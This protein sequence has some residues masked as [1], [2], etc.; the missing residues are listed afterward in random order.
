MGGSGPED[1]DR[2][3]LRIAVVMNGGVSLAVWISGVTIELH[4]VV[5]A[6]RAE[7]RE[8]WPE[9][10]AVLDLLQAQARID[11]VAGT[12]AGGLNGGFLALGLVRD[13]ELSGMRE[14]WRD[15]GDLGALLRDPL[16]RNPESLLQGDGYFLPRVREAYR[17]IWDTGRT[18]RSAEDA[19]VELMLTGTL[20]DGR[21]SS[22]TDDMGTRITE[23]DYDATFR[24]SNDL[25]TDGNSRGR[26]GTGDLTRETVIDELAVASR[27]TSS[28]PGAFEPHRVTS[29][30]ARGPK[31]GDR[32]LSSGGLA[33]FSATQYV[34]DGGVLLNKPIRPALDAIYRQTASDQV[35]RV[36]AYVVPDPGQRRADV[37]GPPEGAHPAVPTAQQVLLGVLTRLRSTDSVSQELEEIRQRNQAVGLRRRA[38]DRLATAM[39]EK[40][41]TG[42]LAQGAWQAYREVRIHH[43]ARTVGGLMAAG[44]T[45]G[46]G[47]WS[48]QELIDALRRIPLHFVPD[49]TLDKAIARADADWDWGQTTVQRLGDMTVDV[50]KR[51]IW[52]APLGSQTRAQIRDCRAAIHD[53]LTEIRKDRRELNAYWTRAPQLDEPM[54]PEREGAVSEPAGNLAALEA[55]L[56]SVLTGWEGSAGERRTK[57]HRQARALAERLFACAD[58]L[59]EVGATPNSRID[60]TGEEAGRL[61]AL[62]TYLLDGAADAEE[63]LR[64]MLLLD[65]VQLAF[66]GATEDVEQAVELVQVSSLSPNL[67]TGV[68]EYHFGAFYRP[69]WRVN[70]WLRGRLDAAEQLMRIL[71]S[72]E[73]LRQLGYNADSALNE[74]RNIALGPQDSPDRQWLEA[75]WEAAVDACR[76]ELQGIQGSERLPAALPMCARQLALRPQI[77]ILREE[78]PAL[79]ASIRGEPDPIRVSEQWAESLDRALPADADVDAAGAGPASGSGLAAAAAWRLSED[80]A[81]IGRRRIREDVGTDTFARTASHAAAVLANTV[82]AVKG[83][84][85]V[86]TVLSALR[87]YALAVWA[88]IRYSTLPGRFGPNAVSLVVSVGAVLLAVTMVVPGIPAGLT[89]LGVLLVLAGATTA[90]LRTDK[91]SKVG[92]RLL[93]AAALA[94]AALAALLWYQWRQDRSSAVVWDVLIKTGVAFSIVLLG[95]WVARVR[96]KKP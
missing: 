50:L 40:E 71:L 54:L 45:R 24:F 32:W 41:I 4:H 69:S 76:Q 48:K 39:T 67:L 22:F 47:L 81:D 87:G 49:G 82:A 68:Q 28:F 64:R 43:A 21:R 95:W 10:A 31:V 16:Q 51:A 55:W 23:I 75:R 79:A 14:L 66:A 83:P 17:R 91:A 44:Q 11:V 12:S 46:T 80:A 36:L 57:L 70:D 1:F 33:S 84:R 89:L 59:A 13:C 15:H 3:D 73:R 96:P 26:A 34:V 94:L 85:T 20:W 77:R 18:P 63:V 37:E 92:W 86:A 90:A 5:Q 42:Q 8:Q 25:D 78:L 65:V 6:S 35:R 72:P 60:P 27:C 56:K 9:Y 62:Q 58:A 7:T 2:Q 53:T 19:P 88:M 52:L 93:A 29:A 74:L 61:Q 30:G 38:R